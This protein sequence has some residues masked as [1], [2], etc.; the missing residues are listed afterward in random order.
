[1]ARVKIVLLRS[2]AERSRDLF[3]GATCRHPSLSRCIHQCVF[4]TYV[5]VMWGFPGRQAEWPQLLRWWTTYLDFRRLTAGL[6]L[7]VANLGA[8]PYV[9]SK[10][11]CTQVAD[12][13]SRLLRLEQ[14]TVFTGSN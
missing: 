1:M 7:V 9:R 4:L 8:S 3:R 10:H 5:V 14:E 6:T 2:Y 13:L 11:R 12:Y